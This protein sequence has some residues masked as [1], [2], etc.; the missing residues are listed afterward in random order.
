MIHIAYL[1]MLAADDAW[2]RQ[3]YSTF[4]KNAGDMR[5]LPAGRA[6]PAYPAWRLANDTWLALVQQERDKRHANPDN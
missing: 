1:N 4:G 5:Y 6:L 2:S 3:L